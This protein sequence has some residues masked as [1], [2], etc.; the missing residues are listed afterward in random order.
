MEK[1]KIC[2]GFIMVHRRSGMY[3]ERCNKKCQ[4]VNPIT[5]SEKESDKIMAFDCIENN[6]KNFKELKKAVKEIL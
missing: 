3:P 2:S 6:F 5:I 1:D 4:C